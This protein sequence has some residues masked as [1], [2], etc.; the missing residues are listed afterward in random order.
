[1]PWLNGALKFSVLVVKD[2]TEQEA[3][4]VVSLEQSIMNGH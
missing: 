1:M 4:M 2:V 3:M